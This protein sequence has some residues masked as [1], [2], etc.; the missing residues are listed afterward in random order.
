MV[1]V[2]NIVQYLK[3]NA[4]WCNCRC[5]NRDFG[6]SKVTYSP[7][8]NAHA[9]VKILS[10]FTNLDSVI[11]ALN[12]YYGIGIRVGGKLISIDLYHYVEDGKLSSWLED[13]VSNFRNTYIEISPSRARLLI[14]VFASKMK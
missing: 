2:E 7:M 10:T 12:S 8:T 1:K 5:E 13:I 3:A 14:I 11:N 6:M 4:K 9:S